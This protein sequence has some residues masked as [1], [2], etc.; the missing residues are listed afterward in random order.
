MRTP[1]EAYLIFK[2]E[3]KKADLEKA[4]LQEGYELK[5][6]KMNDELS[7]LKEQISSQ[8]DMMKTTV[9]YASRLEEELSQLKKQIHRDQQK[10][11]NSFH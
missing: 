2:E 9:E 3:L 5:L 10:S 1:P 4:K 7:Y 6:S 11:K 8:H